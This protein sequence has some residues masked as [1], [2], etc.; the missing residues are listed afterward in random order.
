MHLLLIEDDLDLGR[1]LLAA[2]Q[3]HGFSVEWWRRAADAPRSLTDLQADAV[4]LDLGLPDLH[5][6]NGLDLLAR[7][8]RQDCRVPILVITA[9]GALQDRLAGLD[10]G[11]D[12]YLVKPFATEE[13]VSRLRAVLRR[14]AAQAGEVWRLGDLHIRPQ[15][16]T[17]ELAGEPL[18]L[19]RREFQLLLE[20]VRSAGKVVPKSQI[21]QRLE[22]LG[23]PLNAAAIEM[24][25]FNL[26]K[27]IGPER[28][29]TIRGVGYALVA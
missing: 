9:Q 25:V 19:S 16:R 4:L 18:D 14:C 15:A 13:L 12:D 20:L 28:I 1:A 10:A 3:L 17:A 5:E 24:H 6:G 2:L 21:A 22:P 8:R 7:W 29:R 11:A 23:E 27:K 26:R